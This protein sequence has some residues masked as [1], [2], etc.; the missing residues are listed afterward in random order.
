MIMTNKLP[1]HLTVLIPAV[2]NAISGDAFRPGDIINTRLGKTVEI[3][4]TDS[5]GRLVLCDAL[6]EAATLQPELIIDFATLTG[7]ARIA[8]GA[9]VPVFFTNSTA[10]SNGLKQASAN[11]EE[12]VWELPL[13]KPYLSQLESTVADIAN[14]SPEGYGG[15]I[16]AALFL[17]EFVPEDIPWLHFDVMAWNTR[18]RSGRPTGGEAMGLFAVYAYLQDTY[19]HE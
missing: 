10:L 17:N 2:D 7:A 9:E 11:A 3:D 18:H 8:L 19:V 6:T 13:H 15:A 14:S 1:V 16:T 4:N 5:E 12:L